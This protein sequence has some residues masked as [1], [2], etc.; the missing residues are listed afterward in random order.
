MLLHKRLPGAVSGQQRRAIPA[1]RAVRPSRVALRPV[2]AFGSAATQPAETTES[3]KRV[4]PEKEKGFI[5]KMRMVAMKLHTKDQAPKEGEKPAPP[6]RP[7]VPTREGYLRFLAESKAVYDVVERII[8]E[9][10]EYAAFRNSGLERAG[11]LAEDIAWVS[12]TYGLQ[13]PA[14][15][16]D[17]PGMTYARKVAELATTDPPTFICHYYNFYFA[18]TAGGRM[19]GK[20]MSELLLDSATLKFYQ[21]EGDVQVHLDRVRKTINEL[22]ESW[23]DEEKQRCLAETEQSFSFSGGIM[24]CIGM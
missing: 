5:N 10:D 4:K 14:V 16:E 13:P 3:G 20:K 2:K 11:P 8:A 19:I 7:F 9:R 24:K 17:G 12:S 18:H 23:T 15:T 1:A 21:W 6:P 22:A